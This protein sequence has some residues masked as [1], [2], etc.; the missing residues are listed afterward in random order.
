MDDGLKDVTVLF[1]DMTFLD[2]TSLKC[3]HLRLPRSTESPHRIPLPAGFR[4]NKLIAAL[5]NGHHKLVSQPSEL[6]AGSNPLLL[7]AI[8][9]DGHN[10]SLEI[11]TEQ[12]T[13]VVEEGC[14][15]SLPQSFYDGKIIFGFL[16][17]HCS[18]LNR[19]GERAEIQET[20]TKLPKSA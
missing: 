2:T 17:G 15:P 1:Y 5:F 4:D 8:Y 20:P 18:L 11:L 7:T 13:V 12:L 9:S 6:D 16:S 14:K 19:L 3:E 10:A